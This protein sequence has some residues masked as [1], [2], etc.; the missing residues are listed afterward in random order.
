[1][2]FVARARGVE[3]SIKDHLA[4]RAR[5]VEP[6]IKDHLAAALTTGKDNIFDWEE[7]LLQAVYTLM[8]CP[9]GRELSYVDA[10]RAAAM[11]G[12]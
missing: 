7:L 4:A 9:G 11:R 12:F 8:N 3:P 6:P 2:I 10:T 1:M 5:G